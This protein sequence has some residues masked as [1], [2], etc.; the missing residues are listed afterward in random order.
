MANSYVSRFLPPGLFHLFVFNETWVPSRGAHGIVFFDGVCNICNRLADNLLRISSPEHFHIASLQGA[1]AA[2]YI[3][4]EKD[5]PDSIVF[6]QEG[7]A[8]VYSD[9]IIAML[10]RLGGLPGLLGLCLGLIPKIL[11]DKAYRS[12]ASSRYQFFGQKSS[13]RIPTPEERAHF[14]P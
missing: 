11:R 4:N 13:C 12:F 1:T 2:E 5:L 14:L 8:L 3:S 9:A 10:R 7:K 6:W